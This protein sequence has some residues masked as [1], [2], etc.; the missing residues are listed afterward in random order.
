MAPMGYPI[1][2]A[3]RYLASKKRNMIS[4]S[5]ALAIGGVT[6]GVA[7]LTIVMSVTGGFQEQFREKVLGVNA[8]V[9]VLKYSIDFRE[10]RDVMKKVQD[11][12]GVVGVAPFVINPMMV[13][14]GDHTATGVLLKG[15]DPELLPKVLDLP[16]QVTDGSLAGLRRPDAKPPERQIDPLRDELERP[17]APRSAPDAGS[18]SLLRLIQQE[19]DEEMR[20]ADAGAAEASAP[21]PSSGGAPPVPQVAR[22]QH[23]PPAPPAMTG[24]VTPAGGFKSE[25]PP[26]DYIPDSVDPD[27]C[28]SLEQ[29]AKM[30]GIVVGRTLARQLDVGLGDC[31]QVTSPQIGISFG[32]GARSPIAKQFRVIAVFEAGF[33][34]Y[35]SK[36][37]YTDLYEAQ[38]FYEYGDS[39]TGVEM[40][41]A[42]IEQAHD[43]AREIDR[44][45][46]NGIYHTMDWRE[47]NHGL[48]TALLIQQIGMSFVLGLIILVAACTVIATIIMVVLE[49]KKEIALLKAI[50]AKNGAVL[51]IFLYQGAII[52]FAGT[53][54]GV[55]IGWLCC[56]FLLAYGFPLDPKVYFISSL[57]VSM[58]PSE[59]VIPALVALGIC[60]DATILPALHASELR[61]ADGMRDE[62]SDTRAWRIGQVVRDAWRALW[63]NGRLIAAQL[64]VLA[65][66][67]AVS[68]AVAIGGLALGLLVGPNTGRLVGIWAAWG[69]GSIVYLLLR[70]GLL[71]MCCAAMRGEPVR[72]GDIFGGGD[73]FLPLLG[74]LVVRVLPLGMSVLVGLAAGLLFGPA[75][76][77]VA[78]VCLSLPVVVIGLG[79]GLA[80]FFLLDQRLSPLEALRASWEAMI[81]AKGSLLLYRWLV[82]AG[83]IVVGLLC[84]GVGLLIADLLIT[85]G[86]AGIYLRSARL[87]ARDPAL[88]TNWAR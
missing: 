2:V 59:F 86:L 50:G 72:I 88:T 31:V 81:G 60:I 13:T 29:I 37:V 54:L 24:A 42:D 33:D 76:M 10:Y 70:A 25:L 63:R 55:L 69:L 7:A 40:K 87:E 32:A 78:W 62:A 22:P 6:L 82:A 1:T 21:V 18:D 30:P 75:Y 27:P 12:P 46:N 17:R 8:H 43:I 64:V 49:K 52:G 15:V 38:A 3:L 20:R 74:M 39:V 68:L 41:V 56:R 58:H 16:K 67:T 44:L 14:H 4:I 80:E 57:P 61:P 71:R 19:V 47:L 35:D 65:I 45:L 28:K 48:F 77:F 11:V 84:G 26:D 79:L 51:R 85:L 36:L 66:V 9:L 34:Q 53:G 73:R 5:T 83:I 23:P